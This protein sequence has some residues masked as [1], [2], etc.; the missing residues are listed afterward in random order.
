MNPSLRFWPHGTSPDLQTLV[1]CLLFRHS[2]FD[3]WPT[4][5]FSATH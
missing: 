2:K 3:D 4:E 5:L 1:P